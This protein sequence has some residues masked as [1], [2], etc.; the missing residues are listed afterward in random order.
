MTLAGR[1]AACP[2]PAN[3]A[4]ASARNCGAKSKSW[5]R[6]PKRNIST[7]SPS[8]PRSVAQWASALQQ[9]T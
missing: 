2:T 1:G 7:W 3:A 5:P 9:A 8:T 6:D 4:A